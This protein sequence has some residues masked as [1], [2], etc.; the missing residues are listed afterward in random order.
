MAQTVGRSRSVERSAGFLVAI[1]M[2][3]EPERV[4][5]LNERIDLL[6]AEISRLQDELQ[7]ERDRHL[8]APSSGFPPAF[9]ADGGPRESAPE[10]PDPFES[11]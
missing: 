6:K 5:Q 4:L 8:P 11:R 10:Q 7:R 2:E 3:S 1:P 9:S